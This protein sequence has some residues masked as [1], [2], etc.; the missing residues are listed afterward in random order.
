MELEAKAR[1]CDPTQFNG[2]KA[3]GVDE[4]I[5]AAKQ[6]RGDRAATILVDLSRDQA[7][8]PPRLRSLTPDRSM[9]SRAAPGAAT[10]PG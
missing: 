1:I 10:R 7:R 3:L 6:G 4:H 8:M 5:L 9:E 2:A